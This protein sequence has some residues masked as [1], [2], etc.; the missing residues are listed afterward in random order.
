MGYYAGRASGRYASRDTYRPILI[1]RPLLNGAAGNST[2]ILL[3]LLNGVALPPILVRAGIFFSDA[4]CPPTQSLGS[5][6]GAYLVPLEV[7]SR[8]LYTLN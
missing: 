8:T 2:N 3:L 7:F 6:F 4:V 5:A 1:F